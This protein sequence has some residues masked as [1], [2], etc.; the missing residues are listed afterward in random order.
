[1]PFCCAPPKRARRQSKTIALTDE[2]MLE[3]A[4]REFG[5]PLVVKCDHS[6]G[7]DGV[8]IARTAEEAHAAFRRFRQTSRLRDLIRA[9]R[10]GE[11][12][13]LTRALSPVT[14]GDQRPALHRRS[15]RH[16]FHRLLAG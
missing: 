13:F 12:Y 3:D 7:G 10:R 2:S 16:Q 4:M 15:P 6:W 5:L 11:R 9:V 8:A 14:L 1:M